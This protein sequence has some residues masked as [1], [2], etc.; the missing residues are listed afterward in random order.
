MRARQAAHLLMPKPVSDPRQLVFVR[1]GKKTL[2]WLK[3]L[4][5]GSRSGTDGRGDGFCR[6]FHIPEMLSVLYPADVLRAEDYVE[7]FTCRP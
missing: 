2:Q 6:A 7:M 3:A 5:H 1:Q 4:V